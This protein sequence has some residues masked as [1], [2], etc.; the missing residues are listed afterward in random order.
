[1]MG[2]NHYQVLG[3]HPSASADA[4]RRAWRIAAA[5]NHPDRHTHDGTEAEYTERMV[6]LNEAYQTLSSSDRR[7]RYDIEHGLIPAQCSICGQPGSLRHGP[8]GQTVAVCGNCWKPVT[9]AV[10][11]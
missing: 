5:R 4:I 10:E 3:V 7:R 11:V 9:R 6:K 2:A 8:S 1:M